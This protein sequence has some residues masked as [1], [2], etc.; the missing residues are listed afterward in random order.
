MTL[1]KP[2]FAFPFA[3]Q[4]PAFCS[5]YDVAMAYEFFLGRT[6]ESSS[7]ISVHKQ[8]RFDDMVTGFI[9]SEEFHES[10][11]SKLASGTIVSRLDHTKAPNHSQRS[12]LI[13]NFTI[14]DIAQQSLYKAPTWNHFFCILLGLDNLAEA[15]GDQTPSDL[16]SPP[17]A[18]QPHDGVRMI[19]EKFAQMEI[20]MK[21]IRELLSAYGP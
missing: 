3:S 10:T 16:S 13:N 6:P 7:V 9:H 17:E 19:A 11:L 20:L 21:D 12:W 2:G 4:L 5:D 18:S 15:P 8:R 14:D 1:D